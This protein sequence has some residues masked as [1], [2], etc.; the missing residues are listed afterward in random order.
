MS[1][2]RKHR[3][4]DV[5]IIMYILLHIFRIHDVVEITYNMVSN[6]SDKCVCTNVW[7]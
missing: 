2:Q 3:I 5:M 7:W 4:H 1:M 6:V